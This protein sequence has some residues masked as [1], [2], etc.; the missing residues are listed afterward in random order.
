VASLN[1]LIETVRRQIS[2]GSEAW[3]LHF[4][5]VSPFNRIRLKFGLAF[6]KH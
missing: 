1:C 3:N 6:S 2:R 5:I 4:A